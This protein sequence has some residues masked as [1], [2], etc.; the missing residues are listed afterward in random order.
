M[1]PRV[2]P[3]A[4]VTHVFFGCGQ[5]DEEF[6]LH[7]LAESFSDLSGED[8]GEE[9]MNGGGASEFEGRIPVNPDGGL[10]ANGEPVGASGLRQVHEICVQLRGE[11][12]ARQ[13]PNQPKTGLTHVYGFPGASCVTVLTR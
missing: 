7:L 12:G 4:A 6:A 10:L 8:R 1:F 13:V 9:A 11:G 5:L 3:V 2:R